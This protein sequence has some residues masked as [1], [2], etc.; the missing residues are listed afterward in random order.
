[1]PANQNR[2]WTYDDAFALREDA[3]ACPGEIG[4]S[5]FLAM[6]LRTEPWLSAALFALAIYIA[7]RG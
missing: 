7:R 5:S 1:M 2:N 4:G 3:D 6:L